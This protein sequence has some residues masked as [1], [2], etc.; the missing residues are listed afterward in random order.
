MQTKITHNL[1]FFSTSQTSSSTT[2][3]TITTPAKLYGKDIGAYDDVDV[4]ELLAQLSPEE[5]TMLAKEVDPDVS[6]IKRRAFMATFN[7]QTN[8]NKR[9]SRIP[10]CHR[11]S[12]PTTSARKSQPDRW[13][14]RS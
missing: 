9:L 4:D 6:T 13:T 10:S 5:I 14:G 3:K 1:T 11:A 2:T 8:Q 7:C 12:A